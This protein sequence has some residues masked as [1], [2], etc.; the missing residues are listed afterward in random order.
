MILNTERIT[1]RQNP[2]VSYVCKLAEKKHRD[3]EK[4]F[5]IDGIKL[6]CEAIKWKVEIE[7]VLMTEAAAERV[8]PELNNV[9]G[10]F[11][12]KLLSDSVFSKLSE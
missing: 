2:Y 3:A 4:R 11:S 1:S 12:V 7:S 8:F 10:N 9:T 5:R 6:F